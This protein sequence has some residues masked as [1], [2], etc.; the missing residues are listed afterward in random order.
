MTALKEANGVHSYRLIS[1]YFVCCV[2]KEARSRKARY[3]ICHTC[4][5]PGPRLHA[6]LQCVYFGCYGNRHI[7]EHAEANQHLLAADVSYGVVFCFACDD[8]VY[9]GELEAVAR[10]HRRKCARMMG[11]QELYHHWEPSSL[12]MELL[13][14]NPRRKRITNNSYIGLRGLINLGNTCFMNCIVQALTHTPLLR[15]YFL[16]D[17]HVCQFRDDP[18]MCLVCEMARLFQEVT[19]PPS[20]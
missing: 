8:Y 12:E 18:A 3:C 7:H 11:L 2:S 14:R 1:S 19:S 20:R 17:R 5:I 16:A 9:D 13:R 15:D 4:H 10:V 6:C